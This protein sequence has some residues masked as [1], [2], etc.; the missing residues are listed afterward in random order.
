MT[1]AND[2]FLNN[3]EAVEEVIEYVDELP[4]ETQA[5]SQDAQTQATLSEAIKRIQKAK[6][7]ETLISHQM[8]GA[9]S[10]SP[11]IIREVQ[12][13]IKEFVLKRLNILLGI[14]QE[15]QV[16]PI[17]QIFTEAQIVAIRDLADRLIFKNSGQMPT[18]TQPTLNQTPAP[19]T[20]TVQSAAAAQPVLRTV[21]APTQQ[22]G[23]PAYTQAPQTAPTQKRRVVKQVL[24]PKPKSGNVSQIAIENPDGSVKAVDKDY[25]QAVST[26]NKPL[27]M[28][29][30]AH[31]DA[32]HANQV[33]NTQQSMSS[34]QG[35]LGEILSRAISL[36]QRANAN[37]RE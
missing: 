17:Q 3:D 13:E 32:M 1:N 15:V 35:G 36:A 37:V 5:M 14:Q 21:G 25:S 4:A 6:L 9:G 7:Y 31:I 28:P 8:F 20:P 19:A 30:Q 10:A 26:T 11:D 29:K 24:R 27:P 33:H 23:G 18:P 34:A 16:Q 12:A 2:N 22:L